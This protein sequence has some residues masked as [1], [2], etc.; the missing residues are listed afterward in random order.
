MPSNKCDSMATLDGY[1]PPQT[2]T[3][4]KKVRVSEG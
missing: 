2:K 4:D 3:L 1:H